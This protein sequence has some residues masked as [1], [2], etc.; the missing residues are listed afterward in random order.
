MSSV[1]C[2]LKSEP[3]DSVTGTLLFNVN[4]FLEMVIVRYY[5]ESEPL[6][7]VT[8]TL[9][10]TVSNFLEMVNYSL[11][12]YIYCI[13]NKDIRYKQFCKYEGFVL[14]LITIINRLLK[15]F[16]LDPDLVFL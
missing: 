1:H 11:N 15:Y 10:S 5:L 8:D 12:F 16:R 2:C 13:Y 6:D 4:N 3:V 14:I 7:S 9:L